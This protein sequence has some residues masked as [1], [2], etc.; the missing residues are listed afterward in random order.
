MRSVAFILFFILF[1]HLPPADADVSDF[2]AS[3][4]YRTKRFGTLGIGLPLLHFSL[5]QE[6]TGASYLTGSSYLSI[7]GG[8]GGRAQSG[9]LVLHAATLETP[10]VAIGYSLRYFPA[11]PS[12]RLFYLGKLGVGVYRALDEFGSYQNRLHLNVVGGLGYQWHRHSAVEFAL[13]YAH[14]PG[15]WGFGNGVS[16][17]VIGRGILW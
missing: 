1:L 10:P 17:V 7:E 12:Q 11:R 3:A 8:K 13:S 5:T 16:I 4:E 14:S 9:A 15:G 6:E 2:D